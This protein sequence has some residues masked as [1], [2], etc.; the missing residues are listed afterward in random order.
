MQWTTRG[1]RPERNFEAAL[2]GGALGFVEALAKGKARP[3]VHAAARA[4]G[5]AAAM[6]EHRLVARSS[7]NERNAEVTEK[8]ADFANTLLDAAEERRQLRQTAAYESV[9]SV[10]NAYM[11]K[12]GHAPEYLQIPSTT[13]WSMAEVHRA[14]LVEA[15]QRLGVRLVLAPARL[16]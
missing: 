4:V 8:V 10:W 3:W 13:W 16:T 7:A 9:V 14:R 12:H 11:Q 6:N 2:V 15:A 5:S 1:S